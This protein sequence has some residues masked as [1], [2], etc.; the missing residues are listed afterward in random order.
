MHPTTEVAALEDVHDDHHESD[1]GA[2]DCGEHEVSYSATTATTK[3]GAT[4]ESG[5][6]HPA[7]RSPNRAPASRL[8][9]AFGRVRASLE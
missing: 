3:S 4:T 8:D 2:A 6:H 1:H 9:P 7:L 5:Y